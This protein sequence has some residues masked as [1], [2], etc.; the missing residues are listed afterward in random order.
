MAKP[1]DGHYELVLGNRQLVSGF[2]VLIILFAIFLTLGYVLGRN[3]V[4]VS[5]PTATVASLEQ[6]SAAQAR[7]VADSR[8]R[9]P[10]S[11]TPAARDPQPVSSDSF[12]RSPATAKASPS[13]SARE[14]ESARG[15]QSSPAPR[16]TTGLT[17][18]SSEPAATKAPVPIPE[19]KPSKAQEI[20]SSKVRLITP[21]KGDTFVQVAA[22]ARVEAELMAER[23]Q[24]RGYRAF[25]SEVPTK[26]LFRVLIGPFE[27]NAAVHETKSR[28]ASEGIES[29]VQRY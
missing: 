5:D 23:L 22:V 15:I 4:V 14:T 25:I 26:E 28:L 24:T 3:S 12:E 8:E 19:T 11:K 10:A 17:P 20:L 2:F 21:R 9:S 16:P 13:P 6:N 1:D 29:I 27:S 7:P 18:A